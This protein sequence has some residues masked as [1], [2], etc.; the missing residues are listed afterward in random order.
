MCNIVH[1]STTGPEDLS[2]AP[3]C[4]WLLS[5]PDPSE[6]PDS[7]GL[8]RFP[9]KWYLQG[10]YGGCSCHFRHTIYSEAQPPTFGVPEDWY[11]EDPEN[12]EDTGRVYE[13]LTRL[14]REG[15]RVDVLDSWN[16]EW[17]G[18]KTEDVETVTV[19][20]SEL[21]REEFRFFEGYR[22]DFVP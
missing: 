19:K 1:I 4:G 21:C 18:D 9:H 5:A 11:P 2:Q 17:T 3:E 13:L 12:I 10:R 20:V 22:L 8:L 7:Q 15:H 16:G 14:V 6:Y